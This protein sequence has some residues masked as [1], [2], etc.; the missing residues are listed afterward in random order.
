M[1]EHP[2]GPRTL[3]TQVREN[4]P[5]TLDTVARGLELERG[6]HPTLTELRNALGFDLEIQRAWSAVREIR[7]PHDEEPPDE[8]LVRFIDALYRALESARLV[9]VEASESGLAVS[10]EGGALRLRAGERL[11]VL[12]ML[13]N[14]ADQAV[15]LW[16]TSAAATE[17]WTAEPRR[18]ASRLLDC[19]DVAPGEIELT[20]ACAGG[21]ATQRIAV[22]VDA[23][24]TLQATIVDDETGEA[25]AARV[26]LRDSVGPAWPDSAVFRRDE[27]G[28]EFFHADGGFQARVSGDARLVVCR[29]MEY[30]P[31]ELTLPASDGGTRSETLRMRRWSNMAAEGWRGGDV[32]VHLHYGGEFL[33]TPE[34]A[35]LV[36]RGEDVHFMNMMVANQGSGFVHDRAFFEGRPHEL[37]D[38]D[39]ILRWGEEYRNDFYGHLCMY[40]ITELVPP[41]YSGFRLSE[42]PH[43]LPANAVAADHCHRVGGTLSYA[44]P[45]FRSGDLD[46]VFSSERGQV[47]SVE[48][49][50]LPVDAALGKIDALDVMSYPS[51]D[52]ETAELWYKLLNCGIR[53]A[54]TAGTDTFM[55]FVG[56]GMF[57][58]PPAGN[59]VFV[60]LDGEFTTEAWCAGVRA[61]RTFVTNGP[62]LTLS[63]EG[64]GIGSVLRCEPETRLDVRAEARSF[65]PM[66]R[67]EL[68]VNGEVVERAEARDGGRA[69]LLETSIPI[70]TGGWVAARALGPAHAQVFGGPLFA[71]TS[72]VYVEAGRPNPRTAGDAAYFVEW[73]ERLI[74]MCREHGRYPSDADRDEV[75]ELFRS[76]Q[77][78]Y[79]SIAGR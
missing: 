63:V 8:L 14:M 35:S 46:H 10:R 6:R 45:L 57:S 18:P 31:L 23:S 13:D 16:A 1:P 25:V 70:E 69:A 54:A 50:E 40:G 27:H 76:A 4:L 56:G 17:T 29:G 36:Q 15:E 7:L 52:L 74:A 67:I 43:D 30:E 65:A 77:E 32:H 59:R 34:D 2:D 44:H 42:H 49:K 24:W 61:G 75:I 53:L 79:R 39:H 41:I 28:N 51:H 19:G 9:R 3:W 73:I 71:H 38:A 62:T 33:L 64:Q 37:S 21:S 5:L 48:A 12:V 66:E 68:V 20:F 60:Q 78:R 72:P 58:N 55:N 47:R 11:Q 22:E 26:Y